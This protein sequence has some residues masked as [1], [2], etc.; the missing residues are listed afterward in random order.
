MIVLNFVLMVLIFTVPIT[1]FLIIPQWQECKNSLMNICPCCVRYCI[2]RS[3][4]RG[5]VIRTNERMNSN[6]IEINVAPLD[7]PLI[8][9][10][11]FN[12]KENYSFTK[13]LTKNGR[14]CPCHFTVECSLQ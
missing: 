3:L 5:S 6:S 7:E 13:N 9:K 2:S 8:Q 12:F 11:S 10:W 1:L 14:T 4:K